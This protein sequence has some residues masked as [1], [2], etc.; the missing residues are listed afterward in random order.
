MPIWIIGILAFV[1]MIVLTL[2][3]VPLGIAIFGCAGLGLLAAAGPAMFLNQM[4]TGIFSLSASYNFAV[5]PMFMVMGTLCSMTGIAEGA[6]KAARKWLGGTRGGLLDTV[7]I[8]NMIFGACSGVSSAANVVFSRIALPEL[9]KAKYDRGLSLSVICASSSLSVL[10]PP[11]VLILSFCMLV[12]VSAGAALMA[13]FGAGILFAVAYL[14]FI[15]IY[16]RIYP[17]KIPPKSTEKIPMNEKL[18]T[19]TLLIPILLLFALIVGGSFLGW[20]PATVG[21]AVAMVVVLIYAIAKRTPFKSITK[22]IWDSLLQFGNIYLII[23]GGQLFSRLIAFTGLTK[24]IG[25]AIASANVPPI[26][27]FALV[28]IFYLFCGMFM[29]CASIIVITAPIVFPVLTGL[30]YNELVLVAMMVISME[31]ASLTPPVGLG[32]FYVANAVNESP[33]F[34]FKN[35]VKFF[36]LDLALIFAMAIIPDLVLW[37]PKLMGYM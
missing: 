25:N 18:R 30:G 34:I 5:I 21:G 27:I 28:V 4:T 17:D 23:I 2:I 31:V 32:V 20:F 3:G 37:M 6:F 35:V 36:V 10:I 12:E 26:I 1:V 11:S 16:K 22:A 15:N 7:V 13:G 24:T 8:A 29:D 14:I 19:L 33:A 9:E